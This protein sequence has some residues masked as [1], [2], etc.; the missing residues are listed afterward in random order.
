MTLVKTMTEDFLEETV[1]DEHTLTHK[2]S[3]V[4]RFTV[5]LPKEEEG[6]LRKVWISMDFY[7]V[8]Q[9]YTFTDNL[10]S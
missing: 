4:K 5:P 9:V 7:L 3:S 10:K 2:R 8:K 1:S 6:N